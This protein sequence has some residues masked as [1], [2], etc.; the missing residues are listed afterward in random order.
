MNE[1]W[2]FAVYFS[3]LLPVLLSEHGREAE[4]MRCDAE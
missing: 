1:T 2:I 4:E 3:M